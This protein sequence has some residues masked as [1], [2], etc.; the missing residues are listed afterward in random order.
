MDAKEII[1]AHF[2]AVTEGRFEDISKYKSADATYWICGEGSWPLGGWQTKEKI[3]NIY[4]LLRERFPKGLNITLR[5]IIA[6]GNHV[7]VYLNNRAERIDGRIYDNEIV[8]L[9]KIENGLIVEEREFLDTIHVNEL[10]FGE[11]ER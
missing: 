7:V 4:S 9:T 3:N 10:F 6:E 2:Q 11:L 8:V 1:M 5:S